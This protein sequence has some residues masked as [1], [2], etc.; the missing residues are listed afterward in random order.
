MSS[1]RMCCEGR[2]G[3]ARVPGEALGAILSRA[4]RLRRLGK[5]RAAAASLLQAAA[6]TPSGVERE[7]FR[8]H[9]AFLI[10]NCANDHGRHLAC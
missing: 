3:P 10:S 1:L 6:M 5:N 9:S 4:E 2:G 8:R 7:R